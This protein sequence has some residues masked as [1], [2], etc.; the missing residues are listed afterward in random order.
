[1]ANVFSPEG[2]LPWGG[3]DGAAPTY[4]LIT[5]NILY[6][7]NTAIYRGDPVKLLSSGYIAQWTAATAASQFAGVFWGCKYYS[8]SSQT[9]VFNK[10]WPGSDVATNALII[11]YVIPVWTAVP[12]QFVI[13]TSNSA[14]TATAL[15]IADFGQ[16][17]DLALGTGSTTSGMSGAY[18]DQNTQGTTATQPLRMTNTLSLALQGGT[19][20]VTAN[21]NFPNANADDTTAFNN[22]IVM[23]N[24]YQETGI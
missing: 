5:R 24:I 17:I 11:A 2:L 1:M 10:Y 13:Q 20:G 8:Q 3:A 22:I 12:P 6:S 9:T 16:T 7:N 21:A 4:G 18:A 23:A 14:T 19:L 15:T